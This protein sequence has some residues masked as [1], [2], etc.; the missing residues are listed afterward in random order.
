MNGYSLHSDSCIQVFGSTNFTALYRREMFDALCT[1]VAPCCCIQLTAYI[2]SSGLHGQVSFEQQPSGGVVVHAALQAVD[3]HSEWSW[4]V[5]ELPVVYTTVQDRCNHDKLGSV[6]V[7]LDQVLGKLQLPDNSSA[8]LTAADG[9]ILLTGTKGLW[10]KS[11]YLEMVADSSRKACATITVSD[12]ADEKVAEAKFLSPVAGSVFLRWVGSHHSG[13]TDTM[14]HAHLYHINPRANITQ[15]RWKIYTTDIL[16]SEADKARDNCNFLQLV[17]DPGFAPTPGQ[18]V[19]DL[20]SR[21]GNV[22]VG[23]P[24]ASVYHDEGLTSLS[25]DL[26]SG[27]RSL[28]LVIFDSRHTD[29]FLACAK[30]REIRPAV[31]KALIQ[32]H[33]VNGDVTLSQRSPFDPTWIRMNLSSIHHVTVSTYRIHELP[34]STFT[35][36]TDNACARTGSLYNPDNIPEDEGS[37]S[38]DT[39]AVGDVSGKH[40]MWRQEQ[41][42]AELNSLRWDVNLPLYGPHSVVHRTLVFYRKNN[43]GG[44][45]P[46]I[47]GALARYTSVTNGWKVGITT[48]GVVFRYPTVGRIIFRQPRDQPWADTTVMVEM[49]VHSDGTSLNNTAD[50]R[51]AIHVSPEGKDYYNW[52]GRCLSTGDVFNPYKASSDAKEEDTRCS[53]HRPG[54]CRLGDLTARHGTLNIAGSKRNVERLTRRVFTD[55]LLPLSGSASIMGRALVLYDDNGPKARGERLACSTVYGIYRRKA[56]VKDWYGNGEVTPLKGKIE[57][58]QQTEYDVT[59]IEVDLDAL[60]DNSG[61]HIHIAPVQGDQEFP[62]EASSLYG[63][64]NPYNVNPSMSPAPGTGTTDQYEMGDLSGKFGTLDSLVSLD[65]VYNDTRMPLFGPNS[66]LGRSVVIQ[67]K[68]KNMRWSCS[69]IERGYAP[70]EARELR[71]IASFHHP[72][73]YAWGYIRMTQLVYNDGSKSETVIEVNLRHP[74]KH[75]RNLTRDH[76]WAIYVNPVGVDAT[77]KVQNTRCVAGGYQWNPFYT[78]LADPLNDELYRAECGPD[79]PLRC[80]VGDISGRLGTI[81]LGDKRQ[82]FTDSNLPLEGEVSAMGRSIVIFDKDRGSQ[83]F[84]CA[85]IEPDKDIIKYANIRKPPRFVVTQFI[86][87]V[88]EVMGLPEW[89]LTVD[90][91]KTRTLHGGT[92]IQFLLHFKGPLANQLEQDF[93]RLLANGFLASPSLYNPGFVPSSKR[94]TNLSYRPCGSRDPNSKSAAARVAKSAPLY[95]VSTLLLVMICNKI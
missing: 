79:N 51:W 16:D 48:A 92:C 36:I 77:V 47:C 65:A 95:L 91:R 32:S 53:A 11:L 70:G 8:E 2:S 80:Y 43:T 44:D 34:P 5:R 72:L 75:D 82:V 88:R 60:R 29:S 27:H 69:S 17:F 94:K 76:L 66:I 22:S 30:I 87:D 7:N 84:A 38:Q 42:L 86:E 54:Y 24:V 31:L 41:T 13:S 49:L 52:T 64:W 18:A 20:D 90:S 85:N 71:A 23:A 67:K 56:V 3:E 26:L 21:V 61:Y 62:C 46:W 74:G 10:G 50:H 37:G 57:L 68:D 28:Y 59:D 9:E 73:G 35:A 63:H 1:G 89:M 4:V 83:R 6:V 40:N 55:S 33:G 19:G 14:L 45:E 12:N 81:N 58:F 93:S 25:V 39:Y 78:Q 15:H